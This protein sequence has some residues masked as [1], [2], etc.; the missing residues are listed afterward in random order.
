[1]ISTRKKVRVA[2]LIASTLLLFLCLGS[3]P[4]AY[5]QKPSASPAPQQTKPFFKLTVKS[6]PLMAVSL[7]AK[8][9]RLIDIASDLQRQLKTPVVVSQSLQKL[10][11]T[12]EF[13]DLTL[14]PALQLLAPLVYIDYELGNQ[15]QLPKT[16]FLWGYD[17]PQP[18]SSITGSSQALLI[19][20]DTEEG[21]E[22]ETEESGE[23]A[24]RKPQ[25]KVANNKL[26]VKATQQ[27]LVLLV[28]MIGEELGIPVEIRH[29]SPELISLTFNDLPIEE[30][31]QRVSP[32]LHLF[33][34]A[35]L[36]RQER[37]LLRLLLLAPQNSLVGV[38]SPPESQKQE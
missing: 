28:L 14:E 32:N 25:V 7:K 13:G 18:S 17:D 22:P 19:E 35:D 1:M 16:V 27:S 36:Q 37:K 15:Q 4:A 33:V 11:V 20:G 5:G 9:A 3:A 24:E 30:G 31:V 38:P 10:T 21:V 6:T 34:R 12:I 2:S 23:A 26:T 8:D 29:E